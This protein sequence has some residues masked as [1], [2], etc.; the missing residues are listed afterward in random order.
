MARY[1]EGDIQNALADLRNGV[2]LATAATEHGVP[3]NTLHG[4]LNTCF[5]KG[6][7][8]RILI[9]Q[10]FFCR[11]FLFRGSTEGGGAEGGGGPECD[12]LRY[13]EPLKE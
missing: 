5:K 6:T 9:G 11:V 13:G 8:E 3:R 1:T 12:C 10:V 4:R 2:A 7:Q